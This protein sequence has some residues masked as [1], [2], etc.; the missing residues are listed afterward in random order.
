MTFSP[1]FSN[2]LDIYL[3]TKVILLS[4]FLPVITMKVK[5]LQYSSASSITIWNIKFEILLFTSQVF[6]VVMLSLHIHYC[7]LDEKLLYPACKNVLEEQSCPSHSLQTRHFF[8]KSFFV[9]TSIFS[10]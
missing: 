7:N 6:F 4:F 2:L 5:T 8:P 1:I 9:V 3:E 10:Q